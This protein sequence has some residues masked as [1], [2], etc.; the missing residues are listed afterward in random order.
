[1]GAG[2]DDDAHGPVAELILSYERLKQRVSGVRGSVSK[3]SK[4]AVTHIA[5]AYDR[6]RG[7]SGGGAEHGAQQPDARERRR[8]FRSANAHSAP[9]L[10]LAS[11]SAAAS[12][13][14]P[15]TR[16]GSSQASSTA[17]APKAGDRL[18]EA[19]IGASSSSPD[20]CKA[21]AVEEPHDARESGIATRAQQK[22]RP[23]IPQLLQRLSARAAS[24][25]RRHRLR[26]RNEAESSP[27]AAAAEKL[28]PAQQRLQAARASLR[29]VRSLKLAADA[30]GAVDAQRLST[31]ASSKAAPGAKPELVVVEQQQQQQQQQHQQQQQQQH[32]QQQQQQQQQQPHAAAPAA[33]TA[34]AAPTTSM[35]PREPAV[36]QRR[37]SWQLQRRREVARRAFS[38]WDF[39]SVSVEWLSAFVQDLESGAEAVNVCLYTFKQ[40]SLLEQH[41]FAKGTTALLLHEDHKLRTKTLWAPGVGDVVVHCDVVEYKPRLTWTLRDVL[42]NV[43][44]REAGLQEGACFTSAL[45]KSRLGNVCEGCMVTAAHDTSIRRVLD[46]LPRGTQYVWLD[47]FGSR[48]GPPDVAAADLGMYCAAVAAALRDAVPLFEAHV[49]V[50]DNDPAALLAQA[51]CLWDLA[52]S[53]GIKSSVLLAGDGQQVPSKLLKVDLAKAIEACEPGPYLSAIRGELASAGPDALKPINAMVREHLEQSTRRSLAR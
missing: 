29:P 21:M 38:V 20:K 39:R 30:V 1:M 43:V 19:R 14:A 7:S 37:P 2:A 8:R 31:V 45:D 41:L 48:H 4:S 44:A 15:A 50:V 47:I 9:E 12:T 13:A 51:S 11:A 49:A 32:H 34:T 27:A 26:A 24:V 35:Q 10:S 16:R 52:A 22:L 28:A 3:T 33:A 5:A 25:R 23:S 6:R 40:D 17:G 53:Q 46:A 18:S 42:E 36:A